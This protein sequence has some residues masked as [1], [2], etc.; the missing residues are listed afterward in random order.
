MAQYTHLTRQEIEVVSKDFAIH[1]ILSFE[2]L[3]GGSE[4]T[5][6]LIKAENGKY[7]LSICEQKTAEKAKELAHLLEH[8]EKYHFETSKI[9]F[10]TKGEPIVLWKGKPVMIK[11]F[12]EGKIQ[13]DL[14]P[15]LL[16]LIGRELAKLHKIDA[17]EYLPKQLNYGKEQFVNV[18]KYAANSTFDVWLKEKLDYISPYFKMDLP[19]ALIHSDVFFDNVIISD[20][21]RSIVIMDFEEATYYYR[22]FDIGM[23]IIGICGEGK[24]IN[25]DKARFLL[26]GYQEEIQLLDTEVKALKAFTIYAG[27][28]MTFWRHMNFNYTKPDPKLSDHYLGLKVLVDYVVEQADD[29]FSNLLGKNT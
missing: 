22:V 7:V 8:L 26:E 19:K 6:Y 13:K 18:E 14:S 4:N 25:L 10:N 28:S 21:E 27:A 20:D 3:S 1:N 15:H 11:Q 2:V 12:I 23:M 5:N 16:K 24:M 29:C 9:V 17:P